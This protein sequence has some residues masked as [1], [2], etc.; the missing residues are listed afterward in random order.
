MDRLIFVLAF[1]LLIFSCQ[2]TE[3]YNPINQDALTAKSDTLTKR[4]DTT[5][6]T[7]KG[8]DSEISKT[9]IDSVIE[10]YIHRSNNKL[11]KLALKDK[12]SEVWL[13]A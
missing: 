1:T 9:W 12:I 5:K 6:I 11:I 13:F 2:E 8:A 4:L 10:K 3:N 7:K